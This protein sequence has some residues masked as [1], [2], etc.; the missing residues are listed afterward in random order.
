MA[1]NINVIDVCHFVTEARQYGQTNVEYIPTNE[2][3]EISHQNLSKYKHTE[4]VNQF[5]LVKY[6][7]FVE[8]VEVLR[9]YVKKCLVVYYFGFLRHPV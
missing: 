6:D 3:T 5:G 9:I 2:M 7:Y 4:F 8:M 1:Q